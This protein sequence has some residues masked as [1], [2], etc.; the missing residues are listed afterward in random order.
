MLHLYALFG[1]NDKKK[2]LTKFIQDRIDAKNLFNYLLWIADYIKAGLQ[3][4]YI[5]EIKYCYWIIVYII[6]LKY[7]K[8]KVLP[9]SNLIDSPILKD[10]RFKKVNIDEYSFDCYELLYTRS[11]ESV[12]LNLFIYGAWLVNDLKDKYFE[13]KFSFYP[14]KVTK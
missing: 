14:C 12:N 4:A 3:D 1:L 6:L 13:W 7:S 8:C 10:E 11:S 9:L 2:V 5:D